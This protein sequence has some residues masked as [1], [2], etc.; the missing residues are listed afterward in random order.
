MSIYKKTGTGL[1]DHI[2]RTVGSAEL[3]IES[4]DLQDQSDR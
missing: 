2:D 3:L 1:S 4:S